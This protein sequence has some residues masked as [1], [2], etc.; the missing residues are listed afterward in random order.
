[1][2]QHISV[3]DLKQLNED[4]IIKLNTLGNHEWNLTMEEFKKY[5]WHK[6]L[7]DT[8]EYFSIGKMIE[9]LQNDHMKHSKIES[10]FVD[11]VD[12]KYYIT[13]EN[14]QIWKLDKSGA[15]LSENLCDILWEAVKAI[16]LE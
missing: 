1:M 15:I 3:E 7:E 10:C 11:G 5:S 4:Q 16:L 14:T 6:V 12:K 8:A 13:S 9:I 2:K